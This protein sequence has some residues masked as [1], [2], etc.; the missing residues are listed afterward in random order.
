MFITFAIV[1]YNNK[2]EINPKW[3]KNLLIG[4]TKTEVIAF[5]GLPDE[6]NMGKDYL[7]WF[8]ARNNQTLHVSLSYLFDDYERTKDMDIND[9]E[10]NSFKDKYFIVASISIQKNSFEVRYLNRNKTLKNLLKYYR[11]NKNNLH[12]YSYFDISN[13]CLH[14]RSN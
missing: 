12:S 5:L 3:N 4:L 2:I 9:S 8:D 14:S 13:Q 1:F 7:T 11:D 10:R 6:I